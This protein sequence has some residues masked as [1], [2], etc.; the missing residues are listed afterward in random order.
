M[1]FYEQIFVDLRED[2]CPLRHYHNVF[3]LTGREHYH[4]LLS[5]NSVVDVNFIRF[6]VTLRVSLNVIFL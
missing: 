2:E 1:V 3:I 4:R 6:L 5:L